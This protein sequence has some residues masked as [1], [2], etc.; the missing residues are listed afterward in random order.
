MKALKKFL[1]PLNILIEIVFK[2]YSIYLADALFLLITKKENFYIS[3]WEFMYLEK[4]FV[5]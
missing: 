2:L 5:C 1:Y 4:D 3:T